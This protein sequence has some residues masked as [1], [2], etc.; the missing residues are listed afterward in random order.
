MCQER[1]AIFYFAPINKSF[2][3]QEEFHIGIFSRLVYYEHFLN[4]F[5]FPF[6]FQSYRDFHADL[7]PD[8]VYSGRAS[9]DAVEW[10]GGQNKEVRPTLD[11]RL[12]ALASS[13]SRDGRRW[14]ESRLFKTLLEKD[15]RSH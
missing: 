13:Y 6:I 7:F 14:T 4:K 8:T 2:D 11:G 15:K 3:S 10:F 9:M 5:G 12:F 1:S